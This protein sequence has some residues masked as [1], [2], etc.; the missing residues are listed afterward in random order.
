MDARHGGGVR[1]AVLVIEVFGEC[2]E[3]KGEQRVLKG[4]KWYR[5]GEVV[6]VTLLP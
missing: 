2:E 3:Y 5:R 4:R 6:P 1:I